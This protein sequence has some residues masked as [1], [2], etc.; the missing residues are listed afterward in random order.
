MK[1]KTYGIRICKFCKGICHEDSYRATCGK[2]KIYYCCKGH[3]QADKQYII[4]P[5]SNLVAYEKV[6]VITK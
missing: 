3:L 5:V 4:N 6:D 2:R 1:A